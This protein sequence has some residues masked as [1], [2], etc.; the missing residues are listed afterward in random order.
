MS[1]TKQ[2]AR[3][4]FRTT[5]ATID[6]PAVMERKIAVDRSRLLLPC[7]TVDLRG[8][9]RF[10]IIAIG[11]A[12]HSMVNGFTAFSFRRSLPGHRGRPHHSRRAHPALEYFK[13]GH[14]VPNEDSLRAAQHSSLLRTCDRNTLVFSFFPAEAPLFS[15]FP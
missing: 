9:S 2:I 10:I 8:I 15:N 6:I 14:P 4:A 12:A 1:P 7:A 13:A 5:L 11:K 3:E